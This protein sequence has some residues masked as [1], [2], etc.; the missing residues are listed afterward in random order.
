MLYTITASLPLLVLILLTVR[1][2]A[3][4]D[5]RVIEV[6]CGKGEV[7]EIWGVGVLR[8]VVFVV[9]LAAFLVKLPMFSVHL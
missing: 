2:R 6:I 5:F 9:G 8:D 4:G 7:G 3:V 1:V